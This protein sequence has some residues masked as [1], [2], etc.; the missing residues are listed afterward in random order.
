MSSAIFLVEKKLHF[1]V[2]EDY[3]LIKFY[4]QL[5]ELTIYYKKQKKEMDK[6]KRRK[7]KR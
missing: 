4:N 7:G 6:I 5:D 3:P 1:F 2:D